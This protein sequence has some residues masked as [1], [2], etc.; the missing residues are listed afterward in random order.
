MLPAVALAGPPLPKELERCAIC[1]KEETAAWQN[2]AHAEAVSNQGESR[3]TCKDCHNSPSFEDHPA[4]G[5]TDL[6]TAVS[7]CQGCHNGAFEQLANDIHAQNDV[8]CTACHQ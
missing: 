2:S 6:P 1:H 7:V 3:A 5:V 4:N 8:Q